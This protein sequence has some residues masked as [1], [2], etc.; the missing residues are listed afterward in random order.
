MGTERLSSRS[1]W[2]FPVFVSVCGVVVLGDCALLAS[3][4][5]ALV[6]SALAAAVLSAFVTGELQRRFLWVLPVL[7][8]VAC[9]TYGCW[10]RKATQMRANSIRAAIESF[11]KSRC[12]FPKHLTELT[13]S[14]LS[15]VPAPV[16]RLPA[17]RF[18]YEISPSGPFV[19]WNRHGP[20]LV[21][22]DVDRSACASNSRSEQ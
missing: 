3:G 17:T 9:A 20:R 4:V 11:Y 18:R 1:T 13:P 12:V 16:P 15:R 19:L 5:A 8:F 7:T 22:V 10:A 2:A 14:Y 6:L 21:S